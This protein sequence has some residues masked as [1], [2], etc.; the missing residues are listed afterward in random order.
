MLLVGSPADE[1]VAPLPADKLFAHLPT[2]SCSDARQ[3]SERARVAYAHGLT[4]A[5]QGPSVAGSWYRAAIEFYRA[6]QF[7]RLAGAPVPGLEDT[8][9]R[10]AFCAG[11]ADTLFNDLQF[12]LAR[13]LKGDDARALHRTIDALEATIPDEQHPVRVKLAEYLRS[14]QLNDKGPQK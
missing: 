13:E 7:A 14:H 4:Y 3:C 11:T 9:E 8:R 2:V 1:P 6:D 10:L 12:R 5:K